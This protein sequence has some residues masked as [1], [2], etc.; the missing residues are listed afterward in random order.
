[1]SKTILPVIALSVFLYGCGADDTDDRMNLAIYSG[2]GNLEGVQKYMPKV[3]TLNY[4]SLKGSTPLHS[5]AHNGHLEMVKILISNGASCDYE[6]SEG[7]TALVVAIE[8]KQSK[9]QRYLQTINGCS[10]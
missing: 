8:Q 10:I 4:V 5:A 3:S 6:N 1:M 9:V 2:D 7:K